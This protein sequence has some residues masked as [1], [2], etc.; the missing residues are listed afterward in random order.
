VRT[1]LEV[2]YHFQKTEFQKTKNSDWH[3][4][5]KPRKTGKL[6][7]LKRSIFCIPGRRSPPLGPS[8]APKPKKGAPLTPELIPG[9][10][11]GRRNGRK[12][13]ELSLKWPNGHPPA[14]GRERCHG[15]VA[16]AV[17][18]ASSPPSAASRAPMG[19]GGL[20]L[21]SWGQF[22]LSQRA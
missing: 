15:D 2:S 1:P 20:A 18:R 5:A 13:T 17:S 7:D 16:C 6:G 10:R 3:C 22:D 9:C 19:Q 21:R 4:F 14:N 8:I 12:W 11:T